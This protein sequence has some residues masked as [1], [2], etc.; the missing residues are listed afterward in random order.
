MKYISLLV[1]IAFVVFTFWFSKQTEDLTID[2]MNRMNN[3]ITQYMTDAVQ[4]NNP[5]ITDIEFSRIYTEVVERGREMKA[6]FKFSYL[7][8]NAE[9]EM[10]KVYRKGTFKITSEDGLKWIAQIEQ[11]GDVQVEYLQPFEI[12]ANEDA[13]SS[14]SSAAEPTEIEEE[15]DEEASN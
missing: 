9:G 5:E 8:P 11:A 2:Q 1:V 6:H 3:M 15:S 4:N 12:N 10:E 14:A 7:E 13:P